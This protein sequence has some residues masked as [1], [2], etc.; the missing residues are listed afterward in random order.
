MSY[1]TNNIFARILRGEIPCNKV[2]E[3]EHVLAFRDI[4]PQ[5]P[6]HILVIP[7]GAYKDVGE[8]GAKASAEEIKAFYAA[9]AQITAQEGLAGEGFRAISNSGLNGG[10]EVPHYH[11]HI[12]GGKKLGPMLAK[13]A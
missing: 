3:D 10:Q 5:A 1:D 2:F 8:F 11:L 6:T 4:T 12:L 9:V 13:A 7:K